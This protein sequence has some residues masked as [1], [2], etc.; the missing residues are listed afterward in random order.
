MFNIAP[1]K[2]RVGAVQYAD[3]WD[4]EFDISKYTNKHD[5]E[6]PSR[7]SGRWAEQEHGRRLNFT[8]GLLQKAKRQRGGRCLPLS[9]S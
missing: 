9:S 3:R 7:T 5:V 1:Q 8:L 6:R 2:V 4:L